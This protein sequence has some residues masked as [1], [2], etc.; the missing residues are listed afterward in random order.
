MER[1]GA[2]L[3]P[4]R[5]AQISQIK[6]TVGTLE[7]KFV[8]LNLLTEN[9]LEDTISKQTFDDRIFSLTQSHKTEIRILQSTRCH[10]L[11]MAKEVLS[12]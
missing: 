11:E 3:S 1:S 5:I 12:N 2:V 8:D 10:D 4:A 9:K 6:D 7:T